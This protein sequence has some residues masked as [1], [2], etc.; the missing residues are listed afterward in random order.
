MTKL[1]ELRRFRKGTNGVSTNGITANF[2]FF[3]RGT[4][5]VLPLTY[6]CLPKSARAYLLPQSVQMHYLC[7]GPIGVD[8]SAPFVRNHR[9][10]T[11]L[12]ATAVRKEHASGEE[13]P[14]EEE[15]SEQ[16]PDRVVESSFCRWIVHG[17]GSRVTGFVS[18]TPLLPVSA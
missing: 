11:C 15:L 7:S 8:Q 5:G 12:P 16:F 17:Q 4:F 2:M 3:D 13:Q 6:F 9:L 18:E 10:H 14:W 1:H